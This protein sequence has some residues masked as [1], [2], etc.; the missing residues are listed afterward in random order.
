M[1]NPFLKV[2]ISLMLLSMSVSPFVAQAEEVTANSDKTIE[3]NENSP[4]DEIIEKYAETGEFYESYIM[5]GN[6][7]FVANEDKMQNDNLNEA[8][9]N[10][11]REYTVAKNELGE[12]PRDKYLRAKRKM[13]HGNYCGK[14]NNGGKPIDKLDAA[15]KA[16]DECYEKYGWGK[17]KCDLPFIARTIEISKNKKYSKK[18]RNK[19]RNAAILFAVAYAR[20]THK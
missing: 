1:K 9:K 15:C 7:G 4:T 16:H 12:R 10:A 13:Y 2:I 11:I 18:Y 8:D 17:C 3:V 5:S 14:G 6:A 19:A 20:C